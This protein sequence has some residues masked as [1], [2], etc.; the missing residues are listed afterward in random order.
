MMRPH[1][2]EL[3]D[4]LNRQVPRLVRQLEGRFGFKL[5][6][7]FTRRALPEF[8]RMLAQLVRELDGYGWTREQIATALDAELKAVEAALTPKE[9]T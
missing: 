7:A 5:V 9:R 3:S 2:Q 8:R 6:D 4:N 1:P